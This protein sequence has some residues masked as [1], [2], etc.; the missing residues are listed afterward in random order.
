MGMIEDSL[1]ERRKEEQSFA[2]CLTL[3]LRILNYWGVTRDR[4]YFAEQG[5]LFY[6]GAQGC[7]STTKC[8]LLHSVSVLCV[9]PWINGDVT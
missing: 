7:R 4:V 8:V 6:K 1:F 2:R 3:K 9:P 5:S